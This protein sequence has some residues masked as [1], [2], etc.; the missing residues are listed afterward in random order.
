MFL[1]TEIP[2]TSTRAQTTTT[3][4][5]VPPTSTS[6]STGEPIAVFRFGFPSNVNETM[7]TVM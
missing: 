5:E 1:L 2:S 6:S 4:P 7:K 3:E